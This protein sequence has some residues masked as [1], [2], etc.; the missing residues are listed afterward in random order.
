MPIRQKASSYILLID[1]CLS[2][3]F[4]LFF[5]FRR[6]KMFLAVLFKLWLSWLASFVTLFYLFISLSLS[7]LLLPFSLSYPLHV[8]ISCRTLPSPLLLHF[9]VFSYFSIFVTLYFVS[10]N[11]YFSWIMHFDF[12]RHF[13][14]IKYA[15][16]HFLFMIL[17]DFFPLF[18]FLIF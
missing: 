9:S 5:S 3:S 1:P 7:L 13:H 11:L 15:S 18:L 17:C 16:L 2:Y 10:W 6:K 14:S 12:F 4:F 8:L